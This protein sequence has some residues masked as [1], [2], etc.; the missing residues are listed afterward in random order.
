MPTAATALLD[1]LA[2][3]TGERSFA[4]LGGGGRLKSATALP[5]PRPIFPRYV[6]SEV[7]KQDA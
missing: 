5:A 2:V 3:P 4:S 1:L 6:E 7:P